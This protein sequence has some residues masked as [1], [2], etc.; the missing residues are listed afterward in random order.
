M[1]RIILLALALIC[2]A[3]MGLLAQKQLSFKDGKFKIVQ[4]TDIHWDQKSQKSARTAESIR[5]V[6]RA[7]RP[8]VAML[9]G[10]VVTAQPALD[11]WK[12]VI[13]IFEG[14]KTP[15]SVMMGNHDGE[16]M[17]KGEI[18]DLLLQSPYFIG[19]KGPENVHGVGNH[20][21]PVYSSDGKSRAALL[22]CFDSNDYPTLKDYGTYDWIHFDQVAWYREQSARFTNENGGKPLPALAFFHIPLLEYNDVM[23]T[24]TV[25]GRKEEGV[26]S[27]KINTGLFASMLEM[28]DVMSLFVGH[29]HDNDYMGMLNNVGL[30]FGRVSGWD[31]YGKF[32]RGGRVIELREGKF[33]FDSWITTPSGREHTYYYPSGLTSMDEDNMKFFPAKSVKPTKR[34]VAYS[35]YEGKIK[36]TDQISSAKKVKEGTMANISI[37]D[38]PAEDHFAY[39]FRSL[40]NIPERGVYRFYTYSDDGSKLLIDGNVVVDNDG[41]HS[42]GIAKGKIALEKG[43][44]EL[45]VLYLEDYMG[46]ALEVGIS[47]RTIRESAIPDDMLYIEE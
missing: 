47:S 36:N 35:Y 2:C 27:P 24:E 12:S 45:K 33:E 1:K 10:D 26:A 38:A 46:Q 17:P 7:E 30:A 25:L 43:F 8:D 39:E 15:F 34:G 44:H 5:S 21:V 19:E 29:D 20:V 40:I 9:T 31:A 22:Y 37:K 18:Y 4:F 32:E 42:A 11:G 6:L 28:K 3:P 23:A 14:E 16:M 41:S 13:A